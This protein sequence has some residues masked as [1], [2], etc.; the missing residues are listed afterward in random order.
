MATETKKSEAKADLKKAYVAAIDT[1][2]EGKPVRKGASV[3]V[4]GM[5]EE[6]LQAYID[7][8]LVTTPEEESKEAAAINKV[9]EEGAKKIDTT[10]DKRTEK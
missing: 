5:S 8:E 3:E 9:L 10:G 1:V 4:K 7:A 6:K 2:I